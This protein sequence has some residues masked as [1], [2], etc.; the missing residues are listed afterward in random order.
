MLCTYNELICIVI[1]QLLNNAA[2]TLA[3][4]EPG[5]SN[6]WIE[7]MTIVP[8]LKNPFAALGTVVVK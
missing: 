3:G 8:R 7:A 5:F 1:K 2:F 4:F 6:T